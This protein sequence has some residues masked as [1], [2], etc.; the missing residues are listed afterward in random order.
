MRQSDQLIRY[1]LSLSF[2]IGFYANAVFA[3]MNEMFMI[4]GV[5]K[6]NHPLIF[7]II[8]LVYCYYHH[9]VTVSMIIIISS[10]RSSSSG[11]IVLVILV[12]LLLSLL[13]LSVSPLSLISLLLLLSS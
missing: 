2:T 3:F 1:R 7:I 10:S 11:E 13:F 8:V 5:W 9:F 12:V 6:K 4:I